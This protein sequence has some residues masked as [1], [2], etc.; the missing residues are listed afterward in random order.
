MDVPLWLDA[1]V[2]KCLREHG[3]LSLLSRTCFPNCGPSL[4]EQPL[5]YV[6][7][8]RLP[9]LAQPTPIRCPTLLEPS[10]TPPVFP[11]VPIHTPFSS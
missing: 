2:A 8:T 4:F 5:G 11:L 6:N 10:P 3:G 7:S 9:L 1:V